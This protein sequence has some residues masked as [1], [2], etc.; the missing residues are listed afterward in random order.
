M[1]ATKTGFSF[2]LRLLAMASVRS[3]AGFF[4]SGSPLEAFIICREAGKRLR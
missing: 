3:A 4:D 1:I 2:I